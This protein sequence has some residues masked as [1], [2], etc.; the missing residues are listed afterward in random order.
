MMQNKNV[1]TTSDA[2]FLPKRFENT[3]KNADIRNK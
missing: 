3:I 1:S 2:I